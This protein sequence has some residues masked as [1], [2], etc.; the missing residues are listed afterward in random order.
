LSTAIRS[1]VILAAFWMLGTLSSLLML[2]IAAREL[3]GTISTLQ[4]ITVR[5]AVGFILICALLQGSGWKQL[6]TA[7]PGTHL[8]RSVSHLIAQYAWIFGL[9]SIPMA[10]VFALEFSGPVWSVIIASVL[11]GE[12]I[13]RF[14]V[15]TL[16]L[17]II[18]VLTI[19]RPGFRNPDP[20]MFIVIFSAVCFALANVLTKKLVVNNSPL[21]IIFY[22]TVIQFMLTVIPTVA[23]WVVPDTR[24]WLW[25]IVM[26][27]V[28]ITAHYCF[29]RAFSYADAMV[30][31]PM[32]FLRLPLA[33]IMGWL[34]YQESMDVFVILGA[35]IM[36]GG[37][38]IGIYTEKRRLNA[39]NG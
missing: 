14:R 15:L 17:G 9:A 4:M 32:D 34:L 26:G 28:A 25:M 21:N 29:A 11:L 39:N 16:V 22:V 37:N 2:A 19:L 10:E 12:K 38:L 23:I 36:F 8:V 13:N 1:P 27:I 18:G 5:N 30:V 24:E 7:Q 6:K 31:I 3:S 33:G 20:A 35:L